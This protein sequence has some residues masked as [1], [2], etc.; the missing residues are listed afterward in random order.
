MYYAGAKMHLPVTEVTKEVG[1]KVTKEELAD[2]GQTAENIK[3]LI[4]GGALLTKEQYDKQLKAQVE[5]TKKA[6]IAALEARLAELKGGT[7]E[8]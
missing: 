4:E 8:G 6:E 1:D 3:Q 2:A 7:H 5:D